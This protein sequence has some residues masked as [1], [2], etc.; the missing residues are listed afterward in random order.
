MDR[1][2]PVDDWP[3]EF[4]CLDD[5]DFEMDELLEDYERLGLIDDHMEDE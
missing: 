4:D 2:Y 1:G 5:V 3:D